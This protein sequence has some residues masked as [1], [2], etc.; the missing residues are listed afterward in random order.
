[1]NV[2][3]MMMTAVVMGMLLFVGYHHRLA[4]TPVV[5]EIGVFAGSMYDVPSWQSNEDLD[6]LI[7]RFEKTHPNIKIAYRSGTLKGDYQEWLAQTILWGKEPDLFCVLPGDFNTLASDGI[8]QKLNLYMAGDRSFQQND[9]YPNTLQAGE[10]QGEQYALAKEVN[11]E[12]MIVNKTLLN[13]AGI[14]VPQG[15]WTWEDFYNICR[16]V[17]KD[18]A[19]NGKINQFGVVG[20][21]WQDAVYTNGQQ[22]FDA[23]GTKA[24]FDRPEV[25]EAVTFV[26]ALNQ[27]NQNQKVTVKDFEDGKVAFQPF[28]FSSYKVYKLSPYRIIRYS[29]FEWEC[30]PLPKGPHGAGAAQLKSFLVGMSARSSHKQEAWE[31]LKF[32]ATDQESQMD[33]FRYSDGVPVL[34]RV[35]ESDMA[36]A[37]LSRY[38]P[39]GHMRVDKR[40]LSRIVSRSI[41]VPGFHRY[42]QAMSLADKAVFSIVNGDKEPEIGLR[43]LNSELNAFLKQ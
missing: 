31:F 10:F 26:T 1:M 38:N 23:Y 20:F 4:H 42:D 37:E 25:L 34:K 7:E 5:L 17:T 43:E 24:L 36:D 2:R 21:T 6:N 35:V 29:G 16:K 18:T 19:G 9:F 15:D 14:E 12:L 13:K 22:L 3:P 28:S 40:L 33:V 30:I 32:M 8:L 41:V 39:G 27:L 11:P